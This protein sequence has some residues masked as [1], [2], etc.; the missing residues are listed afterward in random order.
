MLLYEFL[1]ESDLLISKSAAKR[2][3]TQGAIKVNGKV[4][5]DLNIEVNVGDIVA[6]GG[7]ARKVK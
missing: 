4:E 7:K 3:I 2:V 6:I 1:K 5:N